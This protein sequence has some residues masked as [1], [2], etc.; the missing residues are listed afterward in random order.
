MFKLILRACVVVMMAAS[1]AGAAP[2]YHLYQIVKLG[3]PDRWDYVVADSATHRVYVAHGDRVSVVDGRSGRILGVIGMFP[4][5]THGIAVAAGEGR[6]YT[7]DGKAGLAEGFD[8]RT[9]KSTGSIAAEEDADGIVFDEKSRHVFVVD[10]D[11]GKISVIDARSNL[12][13]ATIDAGAKLEY[14]AVDGAGELYV[15]GAERDELLR[16]DIAGNRIDARW[17]LVGCQNPAGLAVDTVG[18]RVFSS[19]RNGVMDVINADSGVLV[20]SLPIGRGS[21]AAAYDP[22]RHRVFSSN[23][24]DGTITVID[25]QTPDRLIVAGTLATKVTGRTMAIDAG[26]GRLYV[27]AGDVAGV[28]AKGRPVIKPGSLQLLMFDPALD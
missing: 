4:G 12:K 13:V 14:A 1:A 20:A 15:N 23:G 9:L 24:K 17:P 26:T 21:D 8:L 22:R 11:S 3:A 27:V 6:G 5:G 25:E 18:R 10:G 28:N 19:C 2:L 7:D 16:I